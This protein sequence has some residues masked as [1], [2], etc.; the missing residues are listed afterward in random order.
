M[1]FLSLDEVN[2]YDEFS[3]LLQNVSWQRFEELVGKIF[4]LQ[5]Y[6]VEVGAVVSFED[7]KR[8]YDVIAES[9]HLIFA[10][11][12]KWDNKRRIRY[13][14]RKSVEKQV[15]RV[16]RM[17]LEGSKYPIVVLSC[18]SPINY[19]QRVPIIS[20]YKLNTFLSNFEVYNGNILCLE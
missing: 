3:E 12:K 13:S 11:C 9:D 2:N 5:G 1:I 16:E 18:D 19:Y 4:E 15:E 17:T 10:D 8:Q 20:V 7:T 14:L 6:D